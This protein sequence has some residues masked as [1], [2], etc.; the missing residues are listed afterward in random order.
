[1][2]KQKWL[3]QSEAKALGFKPKKNEKNRSKARYSLNSNQWNKILESRNSGILQAHQEHGVDHTNSKFLWLK[4][5]NSSIPVQNPF[6]VEK[7][8][9]DK[10]EAF[11]QGLKDEIKPTEPVELKSEGNANL[12]NQYTLTDY[13]LGMMAW[14][15]ETGENWDL[16]IAEK[17]LVKFFKTA[18]KSSPKANECIFA[19][20]GDFLHWDGFEAL[21]PA[22]S[23]ILDADIRFPK[24]VRTAIKVIRQIIDMLCEKYEK[25]TIIMAE[26][27]H[28][29]ASSVW[30]REMLSAF[31]DNVK[32]VDVNV[33]PDPY[34]CY[35]FGST[36]LFYHHGHKRK[37]TDVESTFISK[38]KKEFGRSSFVYGHLGHLHHLQ[39]ESSLMLL[40]QHRTLAAKDAYASRSGYLAGRDSK[41]ITYHKEHGEV[42]RQTININMI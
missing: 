4:N 25:V 9:Q 28:D 34:Y 18:I 38:Y 37:I 30:L 13:H 19:Q 2:K 39:K 11:L 23:N 6:Y 35:E 1:M 7:S 36:C 22:N 8:Q 41:V 26:G 29:P 16:E 3:S 10:F 27:N 33:T 21:T 17:T 32:Q 42:A 14:G 5:K 24:L 15:E 12:C 20:I 31:Y 40:E